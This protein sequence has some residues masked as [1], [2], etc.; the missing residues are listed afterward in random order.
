MH[1]QSER[2]SQMSFCYKDVCKSNS[3]GAHYVKPCKSIFHI[4]V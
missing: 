4:Q 3:S 1:A 2:W